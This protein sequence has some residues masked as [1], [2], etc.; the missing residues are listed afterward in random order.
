M[1]K[2]TIIAFIITAYVG[3]ALI[4]PEKL[5]PI[6]TTNTRRRLVVLFLLFLYITFVADIFT[7]KY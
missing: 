4:F 6:P 7:P 3:F 2:S 5:M 1:D